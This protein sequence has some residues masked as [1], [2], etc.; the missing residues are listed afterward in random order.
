MSYQTPQDYPALPSVSIPSALLGDDL[1]SFR[2]GKSTI[3]NLP[4][5]SGSS[6]VENSSILFNIP[7]E[8]YGYIKSNS[9]MIR[10]K[11]VVTQTQAANAVWMFAGQHSAAVLTN[12]TVTHGGG[13]AASL[14]SRFTLTLPGGAQVSY[15]QAN[16]YRNAVVPHALSAEYFND[17]R[18]ME[19]AGFVNIGAAGNLAED[20]EIWFTTTVDIP[21]LNSQQA[22]PLLLMSGGL[23]LE[24]I[25]ASV[26]EA[27]Y[28]TVAGI[29]GFTLSQLSLIYEVIQVT[30]EFKSAL[31]A[32]KAQAPYL[33]HCN[34]RLQ[35]GPLAV[36]STARLNV[37]LGLS[38]MKGVAFTMMLQTQLAANLAL[39]KYYTCNGLTNF[40]M[41]NN[42]QL[43]SCPNMTS[44]DLVYAEMQRCLGRINDSNV[45]SLLVSVV[46]TSTSN[47]RNNYSVGQFLAG[48]TA[49]TVDDWSFSSQGVPIDQLA[50]E[51][52]LANTN[53]ANQFQAAT[54]NAASNL[55]VFVF[56]D[57][58]LV[59]NPDGTCQ[60]RK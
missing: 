29:T 23:S 58:I 54:A 26:A 31:V 36:D 1:K 3:R 51:L 46:N 5:A 50:I 40:A 59:V 55:Y 22:L 57:S 8:P 27:F 13:G 24:I 21:C 14:F 56:Y 35:L 11:V 52:T 18:Q 28:T 49:E 2:G 41:Y 15:G 7:A 39:P 30:P 53:D 6:T 19:S 45:S 4:A 25:T 12:A 34:D 16:H 47:L 9:M 10:G 43:F 33:I 44:D 32:A 48:C 20:K 60:I 37:G 42:G 38:S 17:L